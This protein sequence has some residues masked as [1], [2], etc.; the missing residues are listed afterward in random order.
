MVAIR[1]TRIG[2]RKRS[3]LWDAMTIEEMRRTMQ[4]EI[5]PEIRL[6]FRAIVDNWDHKPKF[7]TKVRRSRDEMG[8]E[9]RV[10][11]KDAKIWHFVSRGTKPHDISPKKPGGVLAFQWGGPGSY[12]PKT[13]QGPSWGGPGTVTGGE[14]TFR[15]HVHHPGTE[16]REFEEAIAKTYSKRFHAKMSAA[17]RR[18]A[19]KAR[20]PKR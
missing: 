9:L 4:T 10:A 7:I 8:V 11:G 2:T 12:K 5:A 18:G 20:R 13:T 15:T 19:N 16:A 1:V 17:I 6:Q 14:P 3:P